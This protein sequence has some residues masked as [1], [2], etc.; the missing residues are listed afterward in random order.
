MTKIL[1]IDD[2]EKLGELLEAFFQRFDLD[3]KVALDPEAGLKM[4]TAVEPD[5]VILD[6]MLP[7]QDGF[8][9]CRTIRKTSAVPI[10]MLTARGEVTDRIVGLEIGADDYMPKPFEP[11]ELVARIQNVLRR[12]STAK[13]QSQQLHYEGLSVDMERRTAE[14]D[15]AELDLTTMEYQLLVL[16]A[17]NPGKTYT[18][19]EILNELRGIDAQ[20]FSRSVDILVSRLRQKLG[21]TSKQARFIKTVWGTGYAFIG[22]EATS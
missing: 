5:L 8:E 3:L 21:D 15:G 10:I 2:D 12:S 11:R 13:P 18:R 14:L 4:L 20:L 6:V 9:V 1:L 7:G 19:D 16:F 22:Q 17:S